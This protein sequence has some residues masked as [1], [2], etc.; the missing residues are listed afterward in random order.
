ML[1][2]IN[3]QTYSTMVFKERFLGSSYGGSAE[4]N[5]TSNH[6]AGLISGLTQWVGDPA[7]P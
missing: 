7:L 5:P 3:Y 1:D 2:L 6:D 4:T